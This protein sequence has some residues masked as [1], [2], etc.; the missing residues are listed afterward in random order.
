M[1]FELY[2]A[3]GARQKALSYIRKLVEAYPNNALF[4]YKYY[5]YLEK[6]GWHTDAFKHLKIALRIYPKLIT[7][8]NIEKLRNRHRVFFSSK[9][10]VLDT[11][12]SS[13]QDYARLGVLSFYLHDNKT[14][15]EYCM[16]VS[17]SMPN[18]FMPWLVLYHIYLQEHNMVES[19]K[20]KRKF[21]LLSYGVIEQNLLQD[22]S[23]FA[24]PHCKEHFLYNNYLAKFKLWYGGE[25][26]G[27]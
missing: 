7:L 26:G 15:K 27:C 19:E 14:A 1:L 20:C 9:N 4:Q 12:I 13:E 5:A 16:R 23:R 24:I 18:L 25:M 11:P 17:H 8:K 2:C 10:L 3:N 21:L 6:L 22:E